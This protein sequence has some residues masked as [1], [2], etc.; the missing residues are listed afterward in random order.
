VADVAKTVSIIFQGEDKTSAALR[1]VESGLDGIGT[2]AAGATTKLGAVGD[3][4]EELGK[5]DAS[6]DGL[7]DAFQALGAAIVL[8]AFVD[9]NVQAEKFEKAMTLLKGS[10]EA[11]AE[12][13]AYISS[14]SQVLGLRLFEAADA[15][16][17]LT[18]ATKGTA[19]EGQATRDIFESVSTAFSVLGKSSVE[20]EGALLAVTQMV[21]K[22]TV[23]MEEL[24]D[25][26]GERLPGALGI[27]ADAMGLTTKE[28]DELVS[29]GNLTASE[30]LPKFAAALKDTFGDTT[31]VESYTASW[32]RLQNSLNDAFIVIGKADIFDVLTKGL[33]VAVASVVGAVAGFTLLG[34]IIGSVAGAI[35][36]GDFT[37][38][39]TDID[40]AMA[41]A[42]DKT[43]AASD[44]MLG[45]EQAAVDLK[46]SGEAAGKAV[47]EGMAKG[48][49]GA[50]DLSK[51][52][53]EVDA[54][55]KTIGLDPKQFKDPIAEVVFAFEALAKN[56]AV[57]GEQF[58]SGLLVT[59]D[60][61]KGADSLNAVFEATAA[62][63]KDG[64]LNAEQYAAALGALE[65][66]QD[67]TWEAMQRT[68]AQTKEQA[69]AFEKSAKETQKAEEAAAKLALELEKLA[70]N[71]RIALI[72]ANVQ[73][74]VAQVEA[75]TQKVIAAFDSINAG[76]ES[77][78]ET[79]SSLW[80]SLGSGDLSFSQMFALQRELDKESQRRDQEFRLQEDLTR[81]QIEMMDAQINALNNG[82]GM[83]KVTGDGLQPH[84]E[85]FMWEI[86]KA[87]QVRV[88]A[89]GLKMLLGT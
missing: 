27:A 67:G 58:L 63:F 65:S 25:Q 41:R 24:R 17:Q 47:A 19:L 73:L 31:Y 76:I 57:T 38:L 60:Q 87:I 5:E 66:K 83:I 21:S 26:F 4:V 52:S 50:E 7:A 23:S 85:A 28:L 40:D 6:I 88:N 13:F 81:K 82:D 54:L 8:S 74:N 77:T 53:K 20:V 55:L 79:L 78:G 9:A 36:T 68:T 37:Q 34:E 1:S 11:A 32:N 15:Y 22:N 42:A 64:R 56:P 35:A 84:L 18:A 48:A 10:S 14:V 45:A 71:E 29:S 49:E 89:D 44:A 86:L 46:Y 69:A 33:E 62:A 39:G 3:E 16:T 2:G 30:F 51:A 59:L 70:S 80:D 72:E 43:R 61:I 75:D 12:E